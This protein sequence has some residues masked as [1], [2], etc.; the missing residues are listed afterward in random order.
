MEND[1]KEGRLN[2]E[3]VILVVIDEAHKATGNYAYCTV[4]KQLRDNSGGVRIV[5]LSAS[6]GNNKE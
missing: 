4:V 2:K 5:G 1:L 3:E 6:P